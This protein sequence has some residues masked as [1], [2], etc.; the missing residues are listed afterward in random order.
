[1]RMHECVK[2]RDIEKRKVGEKEKKVKRK[3]GEQEKVNIRKS[4]YVVA[5]PVRSNS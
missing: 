5:R 4:L 1:M 3:E 2:E